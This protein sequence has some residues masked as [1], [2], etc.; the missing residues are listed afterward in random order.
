M[1]LIQKRRGRV[2]SGIAEIGDDITVLKR[3]DN[4]DDKFMAQ[5]GELGKDLTVHMY[6]VPFDCLQ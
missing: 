2:V 3:K 6:D 5:K 1:L 4:V